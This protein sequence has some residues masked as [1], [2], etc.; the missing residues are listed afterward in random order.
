MITIV[1]AITFGHQVMAISEYNRDCHRDYSYKKI[2][3]SKIL[4]FSEYS[5]DDQS[6]DHHCRT[7][8]DGSH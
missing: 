5:S 7:H 1:I 4:S 8:C 3:N 2:C 6:D